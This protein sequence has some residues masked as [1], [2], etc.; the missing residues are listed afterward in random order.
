MTLTHAERAQRLDAAASEIE[1]ILP[2]LVTAFDTCDGCGFKRYE[3]WND[4][5]QH[6]ELTAQVEKLRRWAKRE[7]SKE[8]T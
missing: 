5:Q 3:N 7:R 1:A 4:H 2:S 6:V 8:E